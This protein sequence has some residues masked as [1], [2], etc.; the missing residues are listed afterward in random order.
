MPLPKKTQKLTTENQIYRDPDTFTDLTAAER[1]I[2]RIVQTELQGWDQDDLGK[3]LAVMADDATYWDVTMDPAIGKQA[4]REFGEGW[5]EF[6]PNFG[7][8]VEKLVVEGDTVV[9]MGQVYGDPKQGV[10]FYPGR[11][12]KADRHFDL[13]Y[14]Q[15][16]IVKDGMITYVRD[17]WDSKYMDPVFED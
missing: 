14:T 3:V 12:S 9:S 11:V 10:E 6:C 13:W 1:E 2:L 15:V 4:I 5:L 7:C 17:H 8:F 16:A